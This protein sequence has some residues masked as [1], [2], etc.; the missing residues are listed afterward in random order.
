MRVA[1]PSPPRNCGRGLRRRN[2]HGTYCT[3]CRRKAL[4]R[5]AM[6]AQAHGSAA[7]SASAYRATSVEHSALPWPSTKTRRRAGKNGAR[8]FGR[9]IHLAGA[10]DPRSTDSHWQ[11]LP[12]ASLIVFSGPARRLVEHSAQPWSMECIPNYDY[13]GHVPQPRGERDRRASR[14][15]GKI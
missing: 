14:L 3:R 2:T 11:K 10:L 9:C 7:A 1:P 15:P 8:A 12:A 13:A 6:N 4:P 5:P